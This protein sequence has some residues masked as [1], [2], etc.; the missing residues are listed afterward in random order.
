[1]IL[2][3]VDRFP[4]A[5]RCWVF[6]LAGHWIPARQS[7]KHRGKEGAGQRLA[8]GGAVRWA[9]G[10]GCMPKTHGTTSHKSLSRGAITGRMQRMR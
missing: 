4:L 6:R 2:W 10:V 3:G 7:Q 9:V 1:M 8:V 5:T